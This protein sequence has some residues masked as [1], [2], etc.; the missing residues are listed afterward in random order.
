VATAWVN[1]SGQFILD[2]QG[3]LVVCESCP[4][5]DDVCG[6]D[7]YPA[8][9]CLRMHSPF[10]VTG[11]TVEQEGVQQTTL[12]YDAVSGTWEGEM[13]V[14]RATKPGMKMH[15]SL[16]CDDDEY[17][18]TETV[19]NADAIC[20]GTTP[21]TSEAFV[22]H[23]PP[24]LSFS[25]YVCTDGPIL[26]SRPIP[27]NI[28]TCFYPELQGRVYSL[29]PGFCEDTPETVSFS[30]GFTQ[31][32]RFTDG[33]LYTVNL[34][35]SAS[36][37]LA[38]DTGG[39]WTGYAITTS[40]GTFVAA[41]VSYNGSTLI[42]TDIN[43]PPNPNPPGVSFLHP[44]FEIVYVRDSATGHTGTGTGT[45]TAW[46]GDDDNCSLR[47]TL[48]S[49]TVA[50][51]AASQTL[52]LGPNCDPVPDCA[53]WPLLLLATLSSSCSQLNGLEVTLFRGDGFHGG[54][55]G[56]FAY[57]GECK[58]A[59]TSNS[60]LVVVSIS[61]VTSTG[62]GNLNVGVACYIDSSLGDRPVDATFAPYLYRTGVAPATTSC[63]PFAATYSSAAFTA[64]A[65][66]ELQ[67]TN[68]LPAA[69]YSDPLTPPTIAVTIS[70]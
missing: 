24:N 5:G 8:E 39:I 22:A 40:P 23:S 26:F 31:N 48:S 59:G 44:D 63:A 45:G 11:T 55:P 37:R 3:R 19:V 47:F 28:G 60:V 43:H 30:Y 17:V 29:E 70:E 56:D 57:S 65:N 69:C 51:E 2:D 7:L 52:Q 64:D 10:P 4:C 6:C 13:C 15:Y 54:I 20:S 38:F 32:I 9:M 66:W 33:I 36:Y 16:A 1:S 49:S 53:P 12:V 58:R 21:T 67:Y 42:F 27:A 61:E 25:S 14:C 68:C 50:V 62:L 18:L 41:L 46:V 35:T 34:I